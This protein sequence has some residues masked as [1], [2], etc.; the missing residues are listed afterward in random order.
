MNPMRKGPGGASWTSDGSLRASDARR[1]ATFTPQDARKREIIT[2]S[3]SPLASGNRTRMTMR[4][5]PLTFASISTLFLLMPTGCSTAGNTSASGPQAQ[6]SVYREPS[7]R[8]GLFPMVF[9]VG[10]QP[11]V[12]LGPGEGYRFELPPGEHTFAY[13]MGVYSCTEPVTIPNA[14]AYRLRLAQG[15]TIELEP[16]QIGIDH[17]SAQPNSNESSVSPENTANARQYRS[18]ATQ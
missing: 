15:C 6:I 10:G 1:L 12:R 7:P 13:E 18:G 5:A 16:E 2:R 8:D 3:P 4:A 9:A 14:G 11:V 17:L